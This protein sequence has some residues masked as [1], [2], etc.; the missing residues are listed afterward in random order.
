[1]IPSSFNM[2]ILAIA[3]LFL[4]THRPLSAEQ[5]VVVVDT[6]LLNQPSYNAKTITQLAPGTAVNLLA[7]NGGWKQIQ[8]SSRTG[9]VRSYQVR[10]GDIATTATTA[11]ATTSGGGFLAALASL[12]RKASGLFSSNNSSGITNSRSAPI[13]IRGRGVTIPVARF[14]LNSFTRNRADFNQLKQMQAYRVNPAIAT[15][16]ANEGQRKAVKI[17]PLPTSRFEP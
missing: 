10:S 1:M 14:D 9:W 4:L 13:G 8:H 16:F 2:R 17:P 5:A 15:R 3:A 12:S 6:A 11:N 7:R